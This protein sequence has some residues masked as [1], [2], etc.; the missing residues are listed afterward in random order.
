MANSVAPHDV[1]DEACCKISHAHARTPAARRVQ[2]VRPS[3]HR[4]HPA[5]AD[6]GSGATTAS[7]YRGVR[8]K[9]K[10]KEN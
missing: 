5:P 4:R 10:L 2:T 1:A 6:E 8:K 3:H 7:K 9:K